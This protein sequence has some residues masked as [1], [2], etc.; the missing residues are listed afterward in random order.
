MQR[1]PQTRAMTGNTAKCLIHRDTFA[2][3]GPAGCHMA[4]VRPLFA[5]RVSLSLDLFAPAAVQG[6]KMR[7]VDVCIPHQTN[8]PTQSCCFAL[9]ARAIDLALFTPVSP[10]PPEFMP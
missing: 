2:T 3:T 7:L 5:P 9:P 6:A 1:V 8:S 4:A 10:E